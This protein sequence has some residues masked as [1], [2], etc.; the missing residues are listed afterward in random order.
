MIKSPSNYFS[1]EKKNPENGEEDVKTD[2]SSVE[3]ALRGETR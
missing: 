2:A 3:R 1:L